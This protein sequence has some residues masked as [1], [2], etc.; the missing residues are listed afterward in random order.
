V[1]SETKTLRWHIFTA[2]NDYVSKCGGTVPALPSG[3]GSDLSMVVDQ[4]ESELQ[5]CY[6]HCVLDDEDDIAE[7]DFA[8]G[9]VSD[10]VHATLNRLRDAEHVNADLHAKLEAYRQETAR[11]STHSERRR[12]P[13]TRQSLTHHFVIHSVDGDHDGYV[14]VGMFDDGTVGEI[15]LKMHRQGDTVSGFCDSWAIAMSMLLQMGMPLSKLC[16]KYSN[17]RFDPAGR[18]DTK[19]VAVALSPVDYVARWLQQRFV[20]VPP[21]PVS[22]KA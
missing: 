12:M 18:T 21:S 19:E 2:A 5:A 9:F 4:I 22:S 6:D 13:D 14:T 20:N 10:V 8:V 7:S 17:L 11:L 1:N 3:N 16:E 15:F